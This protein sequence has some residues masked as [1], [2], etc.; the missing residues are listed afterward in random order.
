[1]GK[2]VAG[3][4]Q[5]IRQKL[6]DEEQSG[7]T[8]VWT[9]DE[10]R[11]K[12][13]DV[14][15]ELSNASPRIVVETLLTSSASRELD[16]SSIE[17]LVNGG[18]SIK[19]VEWPVGYWPKNYRNVEVVGDTLT[20][21]T[22]LLPSA[23]EDVYLECEKLH[24]TLTLT[25]RME[26][27]LVLGVCGYAAIDKSQSMINKILVGGWRSPAQLESWGTRQLS[28]YREGL[29]EIAEPR[30]YVDYPRT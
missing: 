30:L 26:R 25:R 23:D 11:L 12:I 6:R 1:M 9:E 18:E 22:D 10:L 13:E 19:R 15:V 2:S 17:D 5:I 3:M 27:L 20:I 4:I 28:L 29:N 8:L 24:T 14:L 21:L 16:I 7:K